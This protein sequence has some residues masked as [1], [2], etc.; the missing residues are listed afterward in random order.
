VKLLIKPCT[1]SANIVY[2]E[3]YFYLEGSAI[4]EVD[5]EFKDRI[6][7]TMEAF[8]KLQKELKELYELN[9]PI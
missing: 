5:Q 7:S 9:K 1:F 4:L 2:P 6:D 8:F 3:A